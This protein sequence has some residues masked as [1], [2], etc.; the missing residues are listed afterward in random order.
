M[1][2]FK[3]LLNVYKKKKNY[4]MTDRSKEAIMDKF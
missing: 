4:K 2:I 3:Y 1:D